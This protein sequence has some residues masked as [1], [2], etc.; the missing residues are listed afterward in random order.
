MTVQSTMAMRMLPHF[1]ITAC[2]SFVF[3]SQRAITSADPLGRVYPEL[4]TMIDSY[5][6]PEESR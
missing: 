3:P 6:T 1:V 5:L 4:T 2:Q